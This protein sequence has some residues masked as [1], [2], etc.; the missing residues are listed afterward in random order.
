MSFNNCFNSTYRLWRQYDQACK[1]I[2][3]ETEDVEAAVAEEEEDG[4]DLL[5]RG[6]EGGGGWRDGIEEEDAMEELR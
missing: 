5:R 3:S 2:S 6:G 1:R 4:K